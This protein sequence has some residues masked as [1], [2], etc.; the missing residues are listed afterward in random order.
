MI[1][2]CWCFAPKALDVLA[3]DLVEHKKC[4]IGL[5]EKENF[6]KNEMLKDKT[7]CAVSWWQTPEFVIS[8]IVVSASVAT[9]LTTIFII[10]N[11]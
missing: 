7:T 6:I 5:Y 11:K 3:Q 2:G 4:K 9:V 10:K 8:G 1:P